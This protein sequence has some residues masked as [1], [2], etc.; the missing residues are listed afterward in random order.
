MVGIFISSPFSGASWP[1]SLKL[2]HR[3]SFAV[4]RI[5][6]PHPALRATFS[7]MG[8]RMGRRPFKFGAPI[9][10]PIGERVDRPE[11]ETGEGVFP[12]RR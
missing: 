2:L 1:S 6:A 12:V 8:R 7:P 9:P 10:L 5:E 11:A 3:S 4:G